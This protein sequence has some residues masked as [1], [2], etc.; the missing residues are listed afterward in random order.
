LC[1][2]CL[3]MPLEQQWSYKYFSLNLPL[4]FTIL[5]GYSDLREQDA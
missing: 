5:L 1:Q 2:I 4:A 3:T